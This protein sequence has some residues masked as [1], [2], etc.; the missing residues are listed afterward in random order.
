MDLFE[1]RSCVIQAESAVSNLAQAYRYLLGSFGCTKAEKAVRENL[2]E[3]RQK[4]EQARAS[5][6]A[7][8]DEH[9]QDAPQ[10]TA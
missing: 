10:E 9:F 5:Y 7:A 8:L 1:L 6:C 2:D 4:L 3:A